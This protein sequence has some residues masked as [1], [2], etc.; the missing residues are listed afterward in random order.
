MTLSVLRNLDVPP[1][2]LIKTLITL[3]STQ[4][5]RKQARSLGLGFY[6]K[7]TWERSYVFCQ[8]GFTQISLSWLSDK[9]RRQQGHA[10]LP[11]A[12]RL[13][14]TTLQAN[15]KFVSLRNISLQL[16][17]LVL[18]GQNCY[19]RNILRCHKDREIFPINY[20]KTMLRRWMG[21]INGWYIYDETSKTLQFIEIKKLTRLYDRETITKEKQEVS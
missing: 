10:K 2:M 1:K 4:V 3:K 6:I 18:N 21:A 16:Y 8:L 20:P 7:N 9:Y 14:C 15:Y 12:I 13:I 17:D 19:R 5:R 11:E